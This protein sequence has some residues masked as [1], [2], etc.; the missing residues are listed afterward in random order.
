MS[1]TPQILSKS[2]KENFKSLGRRIDVQIDSVGSSEEGDD[3]EGDAV[4]MALAAEDGSQ[5]ESFIERPPQ[6]TK[7][8]YFIS[9]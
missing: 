4:I 8:S 7:M 6:V 3:T 2:L 9:D 1:L 5:R